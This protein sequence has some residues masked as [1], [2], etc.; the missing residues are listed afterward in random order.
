VKLASGARFTVIIGQEQW[1]QSR[2][3]PWPALIGQRS[4]EYHH[5][6]ARII[7]SGTDVR[8]GYL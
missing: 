2:P 4:G 5:K 6:E 8:Q 1:T 3:V 7:D